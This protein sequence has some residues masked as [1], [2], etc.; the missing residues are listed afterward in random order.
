M[1]NDCISEIL[2][3]LNEMLLSEDFGSQIPESLMGRELPDTEPTLNP[4]LELLAN[5]QA[6]DDNAMM[7]GMAPREIVRKGLAAAAGISG[8][9][10]VP[11]SY[12]KDL[13]INPKTKELFDRTGRGGVK[14][15]IDPFDYVR[16]VKKV[17]GSIKSTDNVYA[18]ILMEDPAFMAQVAKNK[19][20]FDPKNMNIRSLDHMFGNKRDV[21]SPFYPK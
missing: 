8:L 16:T 20:V 5:Q 3:Q 18:N 17:P 2:N 7:M 13:F 1:A 9:E 10:K 21:V 15:P 12:L 11:H 4:L 14:T 19:F 6:M